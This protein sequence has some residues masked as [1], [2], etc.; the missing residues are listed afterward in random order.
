MSWSEAKDLWR[1]LFINRD[2]E[3]YIF[4]HRDYEFRC[5]FPLTKDLLDQ[6]DVDV[7]T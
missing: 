7:S 5:D 3:A 4:A 1:Y 6:W 2:F